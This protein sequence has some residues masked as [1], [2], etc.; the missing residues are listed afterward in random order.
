M[1]NGIHDFDGTHVVTQLRAAAALVMHV[2]MS[3]HN[4][5]T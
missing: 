5:D 1:V 4:T 2:Y 3:R